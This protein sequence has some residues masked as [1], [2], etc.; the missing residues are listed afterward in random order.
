LVGR[1]VPSPTF[2]MDQ[3]L[4]KWY[5]L[6]GQLGAEEREA[7]ESLISHSKRMR[8]ALF[9]CEDEIAVLLLLGMVVGLKLELDRLKG[10]LK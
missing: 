1:T 4:E 3:K 7:L 2:R 5:K 8:N 10:R 9:E 6:C